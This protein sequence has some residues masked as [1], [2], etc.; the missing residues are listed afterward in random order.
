MEHPLCQREPSIGLLPRELR[1]IDIEQRQIVSILS[2]HC[3]YLALSYVWGANTDP[4]LFATTKATVNLASYKGSL[5][6]LNIPQTIQDAMTVC[7]IMGYRYLWVDRLSIIQDDQAD[8][9]VQIAAMGAIFSSARFVL[10]AFHSDDMDH[11]I[12]GVSR[13]RGT[14]WLRGNIAG[15]DLMARLIVP[16]EIPPRWATRGW[17]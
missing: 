9:A 13:L 11:G 14:T 8:K 12:H 5:S 7:A 6:R 1:V 15:L 10:V 2:V 4:G 16:F 3:E 17:T